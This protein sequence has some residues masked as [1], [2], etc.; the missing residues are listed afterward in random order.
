MFFEFWDC[1]FESKVLL[2]LNLK[3]IGLKGRFGWFR[4]NG[5]MFIE[6]CRWDGNV[7][8]L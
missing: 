5:I 8:E 1:W 7:I 2:V 6:G 3:G 4:I